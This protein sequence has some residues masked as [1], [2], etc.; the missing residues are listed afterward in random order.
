VSRP[1]VVTG[2]HRPHEL[3]LLVVS[4][5]TGLAY[6][7]GSPPPGSVAALMPDWLISLWAVGLLISGAMGLF[8]AVYRRDLELGLIAE[9]A[10]MLIGAGALLV[11]AYASFERWDHRRVDGREPVAGH[12]DPRRPERA[13]AVTMKDWLGLIVPVIA[14]IITSGGFVWLFRWMAARRTAPVDNTVRMSAAAMQQ[15]ETALRLGDQLQE[16]V[17]NAERAAKESQ[18]A[19]ADSRREADDA[20]RETAEVR[21]EMRKISA[22][23]EELADRL[24]ALIRH[25]HNPEMTIE[26]LR[27][28]V[29]QPTVSNGSA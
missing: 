4:I 21:R 20:R 9:G 23:A 10:A 17:A 5:I 6:L 18:Q 29:P 26:R 27:M 22:K 16:Q 24:D 2:R 13:T 19:S 25:I 12:A 14:A 7:L 11:A 15:V 28:T 1:I 3:L 8:G